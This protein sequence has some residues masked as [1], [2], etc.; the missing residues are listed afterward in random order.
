[1]GGRGSAGGRRIVSTEPRRR[2]RG[3]Q[4]RT[5]GEAGTPRGEEQ[6]ELPLRRRE[7]S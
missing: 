6:P 4:G 5:R 7:E 1:M 2:G 3:S